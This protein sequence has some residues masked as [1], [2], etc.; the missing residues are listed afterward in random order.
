ME[1]NETILS[2]EVVV[3]DSHKK[4]GDIKG[5][6]VSCDTQAV[7][8]FVINNVSTSSALVLPFEKAIAVGDTFMTVQN[9]DDFLATSDPEHTLL[10]KD[11]YALVDEA[12]FSK[13]GNQLGKVTSF[14]FDTVDGKITR[15]DTSS[16]SSYAADSFIF[17][18]TDFVFVEDGTP[19]AEE[20]REGTLGGE[21]PEGEDDAQAEETTEEDDSGFTSVV[22]TTELES[23]EEETP[24]EE[25][26]EED[27]Q[28]EAETSEDTA[29]SDSGDDEI[30][31]FLVGATVNADVESEDGQFKVAE[32]TV[33]TEELIAEAE[34]HDALLL[35]TINV[36]V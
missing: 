23:A 8:H 22:D 11:G 17:F 34:K 25:T 27:A 14:E 6:I 1:T 36:E 29:K 2:R 32:G 26:Q 9:R 30:K 19:T 15:I 28:E 33:L 3:I 31:E 21:L 7:S 18:S 5:L 35:L 10:L 24:E 13:T 4:F 20:L 16:D 12:V